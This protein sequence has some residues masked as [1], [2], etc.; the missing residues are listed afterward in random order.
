MTTIN[1][2]LA[3]F[4][5]L[6]LLPLGCASGNA[7]QGSLDPVYGKPQ[8]YEYL[9]GRKVGFALMK[10]CSVSRGTVSEFGDDGITFSVKDDLLVNKSDEAGKRIIRLNYSRPKTINELAVDSDRNLWWSYVD[11][12]NGSDLLVF[13]CKGNSEETEYPFVTSDKDLFPQIREV[14]NEYKLV[15]DNPAGIV[16]WPEKFAKSAGDLYSAA[17]LEILTRSEGG[18]LAYRTF[19]ISRLFETGSLPNKHDGRPLQLLAND[20]SNETTQEGSDL[21]ERE[22]KSI[23]ALASSDNKYWDEGL[24]ILVSVA[25]SNPQE[26]IRYLNADI[27]SKILSNL[28]RFDARRLDAGRVSEFRT[29]LLKFKGTL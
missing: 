20:L 21:R 13:H 9:A 18:N 15:M 16:N 23:V 1:H 5:L 14:I 29:F 17:L 12:H 24:M 3:H 2:R 28:S 25:A 7:A 4:I 8:Y 26:L 22:F 10:K 6:F 27:S 11:L 19:V